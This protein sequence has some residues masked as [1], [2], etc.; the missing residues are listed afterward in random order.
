M[1]R[2]IRIVG[3]G[4][5]VVAALGAIAVLAVRWVVTPAVLR[6][7]LAAEAHRFGATLGFSGGHVAIFPMPHL[8]LEE[9]RFAVPQRATGNVR[10][11][12]VYPRLA[13]LLSGHV[14]VARVV[15]EAPIVA[16][17]LPSWSSGP[18]AA[19]APPTFATGW[20]VSL[21]RDLGTA[22]TKMA[23][24]LEVQVADG[25][26]T[27]LPNG[28][29]PVNVDAI[30]AH[31]QLP[32]TG[33]VATLRCTSRLWERLSLDLT[34]DASRFT[35]QAEMTLQHADLTGIARHAGAP[36]A[37]L[38]AATTGDLT[39]HLTFEPPETIRTHLQARLPTMTLHRNNGHGDVGGGTLDATVA[40]TG[41]ALDIALS[42]LNLQAPRLTVSGTLAVDSSA[43][44]ATLTLQGSQ[45]DVAPVAAAVTLLLGDQPTARGIFDVLQS[46]TVPS[47]RLE[48]RAASAAHLFDV[49]NFG[50]Q[51][52]L[53]GGRIRVPGIGLQLEDVSGDAR[54]VQ[55]ILEGEHAQGRL[56]QSTAR[57]GRL[58]VGLTDE[59]AHV[60]SLDAA[61]AADVAD[62]PPL[63]E[64]VVR[65][66][67]F[68]SV[69][70]RVQHA[71]GHAVGQ[72]SLHDAPHGVDT[73]VEVSSFTAA[74]DAGF[75]PSR[76]RLSGG[77]FR[78]DSAGVAVQDVRAEMGESW[79]STLTGRIDLHAPAVIEAQTGRARIA[80][81]DVRS[82]LL[83][84]GIPPTAGQASAQ[85]GVLDVDT[86]HVH[87]PAASPARWQFQLS[88]AATDAQLDIPPILGQTTLTG[89]F[90]A[91]PEQITV[92][93]AST[94][95]EDA[96]LTVSGTL[97][98]YQ[99]PGPR[100]QV[101]AD[102]TL[103][104]AAAQRLLEFS[105]VA[106]RELRLGRT[107][108]RGMRLDFQPGALS[109]SGTFT[110]QPGP[111]V[112]VDLQW[113]R[114]HLSVRQL[115]I[116]DSHS[117]ATLTADMGL[118][119]LAADG[120]A[121]GSPIALSFAGTLSASTLD[122]LLRH[123]PYLKG[124][125]RGDFRADVAAAP[126]YSVDV[127]GSLYGT[128][129]VYPSRRKKTVRLESFA[130]RGAGSQVL[131]EPALLA[132]G[133]DRLRVSG[134]VTP[135][136]N[137][138]NVDLKIR[139]DRFDWDQVE[140][141][142][143]SAKSRAAPA[144]A[145]RI[146]GTVQAHCDTFH[147]GRLTWSPL[148]VNL[149]LL[150][151]GT[152]LTIDDA[153][154]CGVRTYGGSR[155]GPD[156][157]DLAL[158]A[159]TRT[160]NLADSVAC[161]FERR[162]LI[163]GQFDFD[164][165]VTGVGEYTDALDALQGE[166]RFT[167]HAGH[168]YRLGLFTN[169][170]SALGATQV[171]FG[172]LPD[173]NWNALAYHTLSADGYLEDGRLVLTAATLDSSALSLVARGVVDLRTADADLIVLAAPLSFVDSAMDRIPILRR[174]WPRHLV[175]VPVRVTGDIANPRIIPLAPSAVTAEVM[176]LLR[177]SVQLPID[178]VQPLLPR[179]EG[180]GSGTR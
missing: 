159:Q 58:R 15:F 2:A 95:F 47:I 118:P 163:D 180:K 43:P 22:A 18:R 176:G 162:D 127:Q 89:R 81:A 29:E 59:T 71:E 157:F 133:G 146:R 161:L 131:L 173:L 44:L 154:L 85:G 100:L 117:N 28:G 32:P 80:L 77:Q 34:L 78:Y 144:D 112:T 165:D 148:E 175:S 4:V 107:A 93:G 69:L 75:L 137:A 7:S 62:L 101:A 51:G 84:F 14:E 172:R 74:L 27:L 134:S 33:F 136:R 10:R 147:V 132:L 170:F 21:L 31:V 1:R 128:D 135:E 70:E 49:Q 102:G 63:L 82:W 3:V 88:G 125:V 25:S 60:F 8:E 6:E 121:R 149:S 23:P 106:D 143:A 20:V 26:L 158:N 90:T 152:E 120:N 114:D 61:V 30:A 155:L 178:I 160:G 167:A 39:M 40:V 116:R 36:T 86:M 140:A 124:A 37:R 66:P 164:G 35:G 11:L 48:A 138:A 156:R 92:A 64:N 115:V 145:F 129:L 17:Q 151:N 171:F 177:R 46:G 45:I 19:T 79:L 126:P 139:T 54:V 109:L 91:T 142:L 76:L 5:A 123:N 87:G 13:T 153:T 166:L 179:Q 38:I 97:D 42:S 12:W 83:F 103:G 57:D 94:R 98:G 168:I 52:Q 119:P 16:L 108:V 105:D 150:P 174:I 113:S 65:D 55:G 104:P 56:A 50:L 169:L 111:A 53:V 41:T 68:R 110:E 141:L 9:V 122:T 67:D 96:Q 73:R 72:L 24:G 130:L 99:S